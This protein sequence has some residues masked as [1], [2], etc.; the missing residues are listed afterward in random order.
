[1]MSMAELMHTHLGREVNVITTVAGTYAVTFEGK[2]TFVGP[3][4]IEVEDKEKGEAWL[5]ALP[6]VAAFHGKE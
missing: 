1:M 4:C 5:I 3:D 2:L 6:H